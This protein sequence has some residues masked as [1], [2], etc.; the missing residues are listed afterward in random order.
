M[1]KDA[2]GNIISH[3]HIAVGSAL[4]PFDRAMKKL[5]DLDKSEQEPPLRTMAEVLKAAEFPED[6]KINATLG[7]LAQALKAKDMQ[8]KPTAGR[9]RLLAALKKASN[10]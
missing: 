4:A 3:S 10:G 6:F 7:T 1:P 2:N 5:A 8:E 9:V